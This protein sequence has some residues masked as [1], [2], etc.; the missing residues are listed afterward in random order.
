LKFDLVRK[1]MGN[2]VKEDAQEVE[3]PEVPGPS[4][5]KNFAV[6]SKNSR[7]IPEKVSKLRT[8]GVEGRPYCKTLGKRVIQREVRTVWGLKKDLR[9][10]P[11]ENGSCLN[12]DHR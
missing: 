11:P 8:E 4:P 1:L 10:G 3:V 9:K 12:T 7:N 2:Q 6:R 5:G